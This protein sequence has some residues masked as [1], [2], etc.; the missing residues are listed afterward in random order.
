MRPK[1]VQIDSRRPH[2]FLINSRAIALF[3]NIA[4]RHGQPFQEMRFDRIAEKLLGKLN[5]ASRVLD[6][7][8]CFNT[9]K[10]IEKPAA[11]R[12]HQQGVALHLEQLPNL[13][14]LGGR[15]A[16]KRMRGE[17]ARPVFRGTIKNDANVLVARAPWI[18][19]QKRSPALESGG[20]AVA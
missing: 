17:E 10:L 8:Y 1:F 18:F 6:H 15:E 4:L 5:H 11:A 19:E 13:D 9:G 7:L 12:I 3:R 16:T 2:R 20:D 14:L